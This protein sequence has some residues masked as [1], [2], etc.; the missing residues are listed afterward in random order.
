MGL[1]GFLW[2]KSKVEE[3][4]TLRSMTKDEKEL[5]EI[6]RM[7]EEAENQIKELKK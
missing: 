6:N 3:L 5:Q 4:K 2:L 7:I 1:W